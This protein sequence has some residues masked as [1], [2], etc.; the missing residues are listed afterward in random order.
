M[1]MAPHGISRV[2]AQ[3]FD[4]S[5]YIKPHFDPNRNE[6]GFRVGSPILRWEIEKL[7]VPPVKK[8][9]YNEI[10]VHSFRL[11]AIATDNLNIGFSL[12]WKQFEA[13]PFGG[14]YMR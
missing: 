13:N 2:R 8:T 5:E 4:G 7:T 3:G 14:R 6:A 12:T 11:K 10:K 1:S 9:K